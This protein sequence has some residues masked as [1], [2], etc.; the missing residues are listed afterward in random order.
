MDRDDQLVVR[1]QTLRDGEEQGDPV[2]VH[3]HTLPG[4]SGLRIVGVDRWRT[5]SL[6]A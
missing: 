1:I 6:G 4:Q 5:G 3:L 2:H